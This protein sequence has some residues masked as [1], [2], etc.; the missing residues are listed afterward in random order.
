L[1]RFVHWF[2]CVDDLI[3]TIIQN[4]TKE[5]IKK[6]RCFKSFK[7][8]MRKIVENWSSL[9]SVLTEAVGRI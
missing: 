4:I 1:Y 9:A 6:Y 2:H 5:L 8:R 3:Q 7:L